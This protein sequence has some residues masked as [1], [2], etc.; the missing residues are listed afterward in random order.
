MRSERL[1]LVDILEACDAIG[2]FI[3]GRS[4]DEFL[5]DDYFQSAVLTKFGIIGVS[6]G[7]VSAATRERYPGVPWQEARRFRNVVVHAYFSIDWD[8]VWNAAME[9]IPFL[10]EQ[11]AMILESEF[12]EDQGP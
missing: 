5:T 10:R 8:V 11:I 2:R 7:N 9:D 1:Y 4:Q 12:P 3:E 6:A